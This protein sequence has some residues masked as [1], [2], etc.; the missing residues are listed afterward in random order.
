MHTCR[1]SK[2]SVRASSSNF[3]FLA[4]LLIGLILAFIPLGLSMT[5]IRSSKACGPFVNFNRSWD[6]VPHTVGG[7]PGA[8][9]KVLNGIA[10]E[11]FAVPFFVVICLI[12]FYFIALAGAHKRVV[13][14]L[15]E[16]LVM[17]SRDKQFLIRKLTEAQKRS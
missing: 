14:Q 9:Q 7:F 12:M 1:P 11:A 6:V 10:S 5:R 8:L 3:F 4:V 16:Q 2:K 17:E 15:R 13:D